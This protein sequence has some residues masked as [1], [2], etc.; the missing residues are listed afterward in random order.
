MISLLSPLD[1]L[2]NWRLLKRAGLRNGPVRQ[3]VECRGQVDWYGQ[4]GVHQRHGLAVGQLGHV[5]LLDI[6]LIEGLIREFGAAVRA[7]ASH[8]NLLVLVLL[9]VCHASLLS[10]GNRRKAYA[11]VLKRLAAPGRR[12]I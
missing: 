9:L 11:T 7:A 6:G 1:A 8:L 10:P 5:L 2:S 12:R 4:V 3:D